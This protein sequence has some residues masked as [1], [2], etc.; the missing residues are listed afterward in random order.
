MV[1]QTID[2]QNLTT[3]CWHHIHLSTDSSKRSSSQ[4]RDDVRLADHVS[5]WFYLY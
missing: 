4:F 3:N 2:S 1:Q 5:D